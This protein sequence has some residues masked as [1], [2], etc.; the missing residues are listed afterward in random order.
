MGSGAEGSHRPLVALIS[1]PVAGTES[2]LVRTTS[3]SPSL[4]A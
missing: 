1:D 3:V 2:L 4:H